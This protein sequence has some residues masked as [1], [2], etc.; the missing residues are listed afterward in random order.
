[1]NY[2]KMNILFVIICANIALTDFINEQ[3]AL[4]ISENFFYS[5]NDRSNNSFRYDNIQILNHNI[6]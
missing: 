2:L 3:I 1:M 6:E 5:K 4:N